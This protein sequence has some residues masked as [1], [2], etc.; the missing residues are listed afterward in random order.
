MKIFWVL[1]YPAEFPDPRRRCGK[2][3]A[4]LDRMTR[5]E[6]PEPREEESDGGCLIASRETGRS[7]SFNVAFNLF[8]I[9][10]GLVGV[11]WRRRR[12]CVHRDR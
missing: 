12:I 6:I 4:T 10:F 2:F 8:L 3:E 11:F 9:M 5:V 7:G 1:H